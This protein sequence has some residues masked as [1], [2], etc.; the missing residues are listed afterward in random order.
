MTYKNKNVAITVLIAIFILVNQIPAS[1][2]ELSDLTKESIIPKPVSVTATGSF[3]TLKANTV[4]YVQ[5]E[6][7]ELKQFGQYLADRL[8]PAT[9]FE[10]EVKSAVK[11]PKKAILLTLTGADAKLGK[12]GYELIITKKLL[13]L[14]ANSPEGLFRGI[15]TIRQILPSG[16]ELATKQDGPWQIATGTITDYP[17][18]S[19]RGVMLDVSRH[20]FGVADVKTVYR[21]NL[22]L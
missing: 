22:I 19:Y 4:I 17:D 11:P 10:I 3:F 9:G 13:K 12:E 20:F 14:S 8:K 15:Q 6:S 2:K 18:Y 7:E 21:F 16:I 5:G 1:A